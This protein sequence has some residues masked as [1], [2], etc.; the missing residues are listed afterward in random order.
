M[1]SKIGVCNAMS[2]ARAREKY[3]LVL[4]HFIGGRNY[5]ATGRTNTACL[6]QGFSQVNAP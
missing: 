4:T 6:L 3:L 1:V 2:W 5:F